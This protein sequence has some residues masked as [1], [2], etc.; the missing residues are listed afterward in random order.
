MK[1]ARPSQPVTKDILG[2]AR[3]IL[4]EISVILETGQATNQAPEMNAKIDRLEKI[5]IE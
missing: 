5:V 2:Y 1:P 3:K 4:Q